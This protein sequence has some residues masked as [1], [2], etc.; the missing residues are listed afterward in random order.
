MSATAQPPGVRG[1]HVLP[2]DHHDGPWDHIVVPPGTKQRLLNHAVLKLRHGPALASLPGPPRGVV[3]LSGPPGTGKSTVARGLAQA[4]AREL[5]SEGATTLIDVD[6]HAFPSELLGESQRNVVRFFTEVVPEFASRRPHTIVLVDE[7]ESLAVGRSQASFEANPVDVHRA[8]DALLMGLDSLVAVAPRVLIVGT[9]NFAESIDAAFLSRADLV[10]TFGRPDAEAAREIL[11]RSI[12]EVAQLW[13]GVRALADDEEL[14]TELT[15]RCIG[16]DGRQI[17]GL[18]LRG[19]TE[20]EKAAR[21]PNR[22]RAEDLLR[23]AEET[24]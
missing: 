6:P 3:L 11:R 23:A 15:E 21:D 18:V 10:Q 22:L 16:W 8:T 13:P 19:L 14:I 5:A 7:I 4:A 1:I 17:R 20:S 24:R 2:S 9:T 12:G